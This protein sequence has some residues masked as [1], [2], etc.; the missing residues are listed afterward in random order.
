MKTKPMKRFERLLE[1]MATQPEPSERQ[2]GDNQTS[3][4]ASGAGY[5]DTRTRVG[6]SATT[7]SK[8]ARK[9]R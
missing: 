7:S 1:A 8:R 6:K 3:G 9:S 4:K 5:G 2:Q